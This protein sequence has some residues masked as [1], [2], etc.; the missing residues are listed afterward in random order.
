[1]VEDWLEGHGVAVRTGAKLED[2]G[3]KGRKR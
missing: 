3:R 1:V 2:R